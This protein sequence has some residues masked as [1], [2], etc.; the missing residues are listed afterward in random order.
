MKVWHNLLFFGFPNEIPPLAGPSSK[1]K[2]LS[3]TEKRNRRLQSDR[4]TLFDGNQ[5]LEV[6]NTPQLLAWKGVPIAMPNDEPS[7]WRVFPWE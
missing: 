6:V 7:D 4:D 5:E 1:G 2:K 3:S